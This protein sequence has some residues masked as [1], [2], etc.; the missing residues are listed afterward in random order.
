MKTYEKYGSGH[1]G[2]GGLRHASAS[3]VERDV[4]QIRREMSQTLEA[5]EAKLSPGGLVNHF[6]NQFKEGGTSEFA[7][8]LGDTVKTNPVPVMMVATGLGALLF[9]SSDAGNAISER[10]RRA[11]ERDLEEGEGRVSASDRARHAKE[12]ASERVHR[13]QDR[14]HDAQ[15]RAREGA[16]RA[17]ERAE[18]AREGARD[19]ADRAREGARERADRAREGARRAQAQSKQ[20]VQE[21]PL[22]LVGLGLAIGAALAGTAPLSDEERSLAAD[23]KGRSRSR[24]FAERGGP[25]GDA[26]SEARTAPEEVEVRDVVVEVPCDP[27]AE[28]IIEPGE[29]IISPDRGPRID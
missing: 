15:G 26:R 28:Q 12:S 19:R 22:V 18:R 9:S 4:G 1:G 10:V 24:G 11:S 23:V 25:G 5:I 13:A 3:D 14:L 21:Q 2:N 16:G 17:R 20:L 6:V 29:P 27:S 8:N 7:R